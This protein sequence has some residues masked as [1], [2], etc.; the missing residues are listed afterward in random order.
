LGSDA[1]GIFLFPG[2]EK[3]WKQTEAMAIQHCGCANA[4]ESCSVRDDVMSHPEGGE[5]GGKEGRRKEGRWEAGRKGDD[6]KA[7]GEA[8]VRLWVYIV[9]KPSSVAPLTLPLHLLG[10]AAGKPS[11][12]FCCQ[13]LTAPQGLCQK[14]PS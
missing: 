11:P 1:G 14:P 3:F 10:S 5:E 8:G 9:L 12:S 2:E 7:G 4:A 6:K 13:I